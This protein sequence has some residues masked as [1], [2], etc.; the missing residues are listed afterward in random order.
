[1]DIIIQARTGSTRLPSKILYKCTNNLNFL[2][3]CINR[4][5]KSNAKRIIIATTNKKEDDIIEDICIQNDILY[6]RGSETN[7][8][9]RYYNTALK[10]N[11]KNIIRITSDC[12][13]ID[14]RIINNMIDIY[15]NIESTQSID[16][17]QL[18]YYNPGGFPDGFNPEIF[19]FNALEKAY[20]N[21]T[22]DYDKEHV[23]PYIHK[24]L[25]NFKHSISIK[26]EDFPNINFIK[27]HL[28]LDN[29]RD[30]KMLR[31]VIDHFER[32]NI[33]SY[34]YIDV[35]NFINNNCY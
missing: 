12:P 20:Q 27:L 7:V 11:C 13:L 15:S 18:N 17:L 10:Y 9:E 33:D 25:I 24:F 34:S 26:L 19:S 29:K 21:A 23:S 14:Y 30:L 22:S 3:Y 32:Q 16:G 6:F 35:L 1:M 8:L 2:E 28:S 5:K 4:C 31:T